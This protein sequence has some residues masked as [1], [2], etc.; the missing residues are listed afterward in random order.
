MIQSEVKGAAHPLKPPES[1]CSH[2][3]Y[4]HQ[5]RTRGGEP[6]S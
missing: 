5:K 6:G 1:Y 3:A 2:R 4:L